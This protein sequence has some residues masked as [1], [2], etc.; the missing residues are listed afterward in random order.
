MLK[1]EIS[2]TLQKPHPLWTIHP[3]DTGKASPAV[4]GTVCNASAKCADWIFSFPARS[5]IVRAMSGYDPRSARQSV[6]PQPKTGPKAMLVLDC[7]LATA[8]MPARQGIGLD[9]LGKILNCLMGDF[10]VLFSP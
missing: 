6:T 4:L 5:V 3:K 2:L 10:H 7:L 8:S 1:F 9:P